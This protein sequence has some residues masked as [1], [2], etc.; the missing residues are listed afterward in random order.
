MN[1]K[2]FDVSGNNIIPSKTKVRWIRDVFVSASSPHHIR[3]M[4]FYQQRRQQ[5]TVT[6]APASTV[7]NLISSTSGTLNHVIKETTGPLLP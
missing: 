3:Q 1:V 7:Q 2:M 6:E 5:I 4:L